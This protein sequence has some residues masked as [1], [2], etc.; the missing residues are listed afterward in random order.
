MVQMVPVV[1]IE[2]LVHLPVVVRPVSVQALISVLLV[3]SQEEGGGEELVH[4]GYED[5]L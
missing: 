1:P 2:P 4:I 5:G 3:E